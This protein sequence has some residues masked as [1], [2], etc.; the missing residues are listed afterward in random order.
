[1]KRKSSMLLPLAAAMTSLFGA[2]APPGGGGVSRVVRKTHPFYSSKIPGMPEPAQ[3]F[4]RPPHE[5]SKKRARK[6]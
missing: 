4:V 5:R 3:K 6:P 2:T 1:M